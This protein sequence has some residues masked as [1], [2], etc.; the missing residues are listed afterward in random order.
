MELAVFFLQEI[1]QI[2]EIHGN[3]GNVIGCFFPQEITQIMEM[4]YF[5]VFS[6]ENASFGS[7]NGTR[8]REKTARNLRVFGSQNGI[9]TLRK[10]RGLDPKMVAVATQTGIEHFGIISPGIALQEPF[11]WRNRAPKG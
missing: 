6:Q 10:P 7:Q 9:K 1:T 8:N 11:P 4:I 3:H 5:W 2:M